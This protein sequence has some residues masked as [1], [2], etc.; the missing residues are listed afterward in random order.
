MGTSELLFL[1]CNS[2]FARQRRVDKPE[3][4]HPEQ[5][6][7]GSGHLGRGIIWSFFLEHKCRSKFS[8]RNVRAGRTDSEEENTGVSSH[9]HSWGDL[10]VS[11]RACSP[12]S[13][14]TNDTTLA[15][16]LATSHKTLEALAASEAIHEE[17]NLSLTTH[18]SQQRC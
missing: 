1:S 4:G 10:C 13:P 6:T 16:S 17:Q 2:H 14:S 18:H 11:P 15:L 7:L 8:H 3:S 12:P 9:W 5:G